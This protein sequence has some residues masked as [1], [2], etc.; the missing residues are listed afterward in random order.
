[1][2]FNVGHKYRADG[3]QVESWR[4][5]FVITDPSVNCRFPMLES[6]SE[7][8]MTK[9]RSLALRARRQWEFAVLGERYGSFFVDAFEDVQWESRAQA[10]EAHVDYRTNNSRQLLQERT[11][12]GITERR[13]PPLRSVRSTRMISW[14]M[15]AF[16][17]YFLDKVRWSS[18]RW[19]ARFRLFNGLETFYRSHFDPRVYPWAESHGPFRSRAAQEP[20]IWPVIVPRYSRRS[21]RFL[22]RND[23]KHFISS[24]YDFFFHTIFSKTL[25]LG[26]WRS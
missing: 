4:F 22:V 25:G 19:T 18:L 17:F 2:S 7:C 3:N 8:C 1:M 11:V 16:F 21:H 13:P 24:E 26:Q 15:R 10:S 9:P 12:Q 23:R 5:C 14:F 20:Y 6:G